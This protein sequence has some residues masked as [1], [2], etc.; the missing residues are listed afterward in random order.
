M[1]NLMSL[2]GHES[3]TSTHL[4]FISN[5]DCGKTHAAEVARRMGISRQ[6]VYKITRELQK[7]GILTLEIDPADKRQ[8]TVNMTS[9]GEKVVTDARACLG[10]IELELTSRIGRKHFNQL[11][12][13]LRQEFGPILGSTES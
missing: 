10:E 13:S 8:K 9:L 5:L 3:L 7:L 11:S 6:A 12:T 1:L 4:T 2:R